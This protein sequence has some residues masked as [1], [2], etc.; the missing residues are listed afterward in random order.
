MPPSI[1]SDLDLIE[2]LDEAPDPSVSPN[3]MLV[4]PDAKAPRVQRQASKTKLR[5]LAEALYTM[6]DCTLQEL[7]KRPEFADLPAS[8]LYRWRDQDGWDLKRIHVNKAALLRVYKQMGD[9]LAEKRLES[10]QRLQTI[11]NL[12]YDM[13]TDTID[14]LKR[15]S[16]DKAATVLINTVRAKDE[17]HEKVVSA[18]NPENQPQEMR[19]LDSLSEADLFEMAQMVVG[20]RLIAAKKVE[21]VA[22][23]TIE[24]PTEAGIEGEDAGGDGESGGLA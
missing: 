20:K 3:S 13:I 16:F 15:P 6:S 8:R 9:N 5:L 17:I 12:T 19:V 18:V 21:P 7:K 14:P 24:A 1:E 2:I 22:Q 4:A 23:L 10:L 11:E